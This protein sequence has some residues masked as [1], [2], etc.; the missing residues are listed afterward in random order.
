MSSATEDDPIPLDDDTS[1]DVEPSTEELRLL[2]CT[3][4]DHGERLDR[5]IARHFPDLS[6][7]TAQKLIKDEQV[8]LDGEAPPRGAKTQVQTG[9]SWTV[10]P[11]LS[12][13]VALTPQAIALDILYEDDDL[14]AVNKPAGMVVHPSLGHPD[15]TLVNAVLHHVRDMERRPEDLRPGIVHR[16]DRETSGAILVAKHAE[17]HQALQATFQERRIEKRYLAV[18]KGVPEP[19]HGTYD[20]LYGRHP[21][22]RKKFSSRVPEGKQ[23]ITHY[24]IVETYP[25]VCLAEVVI[26]TGRTHQIRVHFSDHG[27]ALVGDQTYGSRRTLR[28]PDVKALAYAFD[29]TALHA[30]QLRLR[31]PLRPKKKLRI[32]APV[33]EDLDTLIERMRD[34]SRQRGKDPQVQWT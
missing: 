27:Y 23:A 4:E 28:D 15:G 30:W 20:T 22:H 6:R 31:H 19:P 33:P 21:H 2:H 10:R 7:S 17:A 29:R 3:D 8:M 9:Q 26:E 12:N 11:S 24:V 14:L 13:P 25:G 18:L 5:V 34:I 1:A 16:L 32:E